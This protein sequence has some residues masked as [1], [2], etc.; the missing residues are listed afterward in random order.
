[1]HTILMGWLLLQMKKIVLRCFFWRK[2]ENWLFSI[3]TLDEKSLEVYNV[4]DIEF[5]EVNFLLYDFAG[6]IDGKKIKRLKKTV[7]GG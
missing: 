5:I 2:Q 7:S 6:D 4:H 3:W 1:M